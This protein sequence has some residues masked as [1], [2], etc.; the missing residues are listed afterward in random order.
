MI[1]T[2]DAIP[3]VQRD[4]VTWFFPRLPDS[5]SWSGSVEGRGEEEEAGLVAV[6]GLAGLPPADDGGSSGGL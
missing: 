4:T 1:F 2:H 3:T 6:G 5:A